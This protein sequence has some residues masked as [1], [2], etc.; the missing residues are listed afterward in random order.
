MGRLSFGDKRMSPTMTS[1]GIDRMT[2]DERLKLIQE[3]WDSMAGEVEKSPLTQAQQEEL[4]RRLA[5]DD[6]HPDDAIP[7]E[8]IKAE[9]RARRNR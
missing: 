6:A 8:V 5:D 1:L 3:I 9:A 4:A 7:W 2:F